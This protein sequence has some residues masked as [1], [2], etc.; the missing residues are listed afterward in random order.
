MVTWGLGGPHMP[1]TPSAPP[2]PALRPAHV[3]PRTSPPDIHPESPRRAV[4]GR[5][6]FFPAPQHSGH[7]PP[8]L[9]SPAAL[10]TSSW[11]PV[12]DDCELSC[13]DH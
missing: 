5:A 1:P 13:C 7:G 12:S 8:R 3:A 6:H 2:S 11:L 10:R 9:G 4:A